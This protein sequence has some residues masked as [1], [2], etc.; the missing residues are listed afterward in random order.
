MTWS[1]CKYTQVTRHDVRIFSITAQFLGLN[2]D[3]GEKGDMR[4]IFPTSFNIYNVF[5]DLKTSR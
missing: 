3:V 4:K 1:Q 5:F 2:L